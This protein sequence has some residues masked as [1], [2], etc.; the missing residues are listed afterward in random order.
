MRLCLLVPALLALTLSS[1]LAKDGKTPPAS[2]RCSELALSLGFVS[3]TEETTFDEIPDGC[4]A[5]N[6]FVDFGPYARYS[7]GAVVIHSPDLFSGHFDYEAPPEE[8]ELPSSL[9]VAAT[10]FLFAPQTGSALNDYIIETQSEPMD[11]HFDYSWDKPSGTFSL[12]DFSVGGFDKS[13]ITLAAKATGFDRMPTDFDSIDNLPGALEEL[14]FTL[15]D[16]RF[17][18]V[19]TNPAILGGGLVESEDPRITVAN[20]Q[21][22][23][24]AFVTALPTET[25]SDTSKTALTTLIN[26]FPRLTGDYQLH[27]T[28]DPAFSFNRLAINDLTG[29]LSLLS[30]FKLDATHQPAD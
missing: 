19:M 13:R 7:V 25:I 14:T 30:S 11:I 17:F 18:S 21:K 15:K 9:E 16:A 1:A 4:E 8:F 27:L 10:D 28:A 3:A 24:V 26:S 22:A 23:A 29:A 20:Y 5:R 12:N 2:N 6:F